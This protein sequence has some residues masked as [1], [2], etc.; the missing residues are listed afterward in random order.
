LFKE[1]HKCILY[2]VPVACRNLHNLFRL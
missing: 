1:A 2:Y